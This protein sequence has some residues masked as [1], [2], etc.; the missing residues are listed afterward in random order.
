MRLIEPLEFASS[1]PRFVAALVDRLLP[2]LKWLIKD[3]PGNEGQD[4]ALG[5]LTSW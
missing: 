3:L 2:L 1:L 5:A 4:I